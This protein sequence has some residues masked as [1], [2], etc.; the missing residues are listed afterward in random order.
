MRIQGGVKSIAMGGRPS[1]LPIQ[2]IG[3]TK[4][5]NNY[6]FAYM[7]QITTLATGMGSADQMK[8]WTAA[9]NY[10]DLPLNR[11]TDNS[12]NVRDNILR[13]H[14]EDGIPAQFVY[15][16]ADCR[17]YY[18]PSMIT[19]VTAIWKKAADAAWGT[20]K[21]IAGSLPHANETLAVRKM[22]SEEMKQR[23]RLEGYRPIPKI[24]LVALPKS[25]IHGKKVPWA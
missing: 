3:G 19:N 10:S 25:P 1:K 12:L 20:D 11:S 18:E 17:L 4:G 14:L 6:P 22:R 7:R 9:T 23:E 24:D 13:D 21:C 5:A 16:A 8:N 15:E 2:G